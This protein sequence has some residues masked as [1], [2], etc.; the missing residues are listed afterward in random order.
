[1]L[2]I[3]Q[4]PG[5]SILPFWVLQEGSSEENQYNQPAEKLDFS[6]VKIK[7]AGLTRLSGV[8]REVC[9]HAEPLS[10]FIERINCSLL[11]FIKVE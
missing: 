5:Q 2:S 3:N 9:L 4:F 1:M 7:L 10:S 8:L 11:T 6:K